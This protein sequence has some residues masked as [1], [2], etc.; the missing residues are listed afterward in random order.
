MVSLQREKSQGASVQSL[1]GFLP[2]GSGLIITNSAGV[3]AWSRAIITS[4]GTVSVSV[5]AS[6]VRD[7]CILGYSCSCTL[8]A[9]QH[10]LEMA[11]ADGVVQ[12]RERELPTDFAARHS[13]QSATKSSA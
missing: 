6:A 2:H 9:V 11:T 13:S 10:L 5:S 3:S 8:C 12:P 7:R 1:Q 4:L